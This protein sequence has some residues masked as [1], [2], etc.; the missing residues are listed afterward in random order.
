MGG[1]SRGGLAPPPY[2]CQRRQLQQVVAS[3]WRADRRG[4]RH[5]TGVWSL[6][7]C[8]GGGTRLGRQAWP[9]DPVFFNPET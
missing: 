7:L 6:W 1:T 5:L 2:A 8:I 4:G 3:L 9:D